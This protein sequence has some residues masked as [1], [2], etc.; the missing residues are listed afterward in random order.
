M[1]YPDDKQFDQITLLITGLTNVQCNKRI[2][3]TKLDNKFSTISVLLNMLAGV[4]KEAV[5]LL[6]IRRTMDMQIKGAH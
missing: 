6:S 2:K 3:V 4:L 5:P 1:Y